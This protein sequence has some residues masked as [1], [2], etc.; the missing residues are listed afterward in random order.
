MPEITALQKFNCPACG[1]EAVWTPAKKSLV[2]P[3]CGTNSSVALNTDTTSIR[4]NDLLQA[5]HAMPTDEMGWAA[6]KKTVRCQSCN[7]VSVF[8][9]KRMAQNCDFC[10]SASLISI[11]DVKAPVRPSSLLPFS[12]A[13]TKVRE[14]IRQWYNSHWFAPNA[15]A[16][17]ALTDTLHGIYLPYW[18]F[19]AQVHADWEAE[20]GTHYYTRDSQGRSQQHTRWEPAAGSVDNFFDDLLVPASRGVHPALLE[21]VS[22]FPTTDKLLPYDP[23]YVSGWVVE[24]YQIDLSSA[25]AASHQSMEEAMQAL[26]SQQVPGDT[27]RGLHVATQYSGQMF[28][29][30]LLP[31]WLLSYT[32]GSKSYQVLVNGYTGKI[33]GEYPISWVKVTLVVIAVI[34]AVIVFASLQES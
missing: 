3:Y 29:H 13:D 15:L 21:E 9:P 8:D 14:D 27:Q 19:D 22:P 20:A 16:G 2:C 4:E 28:K 11:D 33:A 7:A 23:G 18:T 17:K 31:V 5:L 32:Y 6:E 10:G 1:A 25:A 12:I 24:Q 26:C 34:I 30:V